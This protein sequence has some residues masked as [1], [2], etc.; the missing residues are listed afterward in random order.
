[1][2]ARVRELGRHIKQGSLAVVSVMDGAERGS[3]VLTLF[4]W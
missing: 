2:M 1:M 4:W 3:I